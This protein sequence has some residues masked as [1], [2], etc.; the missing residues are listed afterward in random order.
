MCPHRC[1]YWMCVL[2]VC[3]YKYVHVW[4]CMCCVCC[5]R[6]MCVLC[7]FVCVCVRTHVSV[8]CVC[9]CVLG[10]CVCVCARVCMHIYS[11]ISEVLNNYSHEIKL[12][13]VLQLS[14]HFTWHFCR[15]NGAAFAIDISM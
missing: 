14:S 9:A 8:V 6:W 2:C 5:V 12:C 3:V 1:V 7:V 4:I 11:H 13:Q 15:H 10:V